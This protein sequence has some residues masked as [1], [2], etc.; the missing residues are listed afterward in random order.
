M[1]T[2][3]DL[4]RRIAPVLAFFAGLGSSAARAEAQ[5]GGDLAITGV[6]I[7]D[8]RRGL[9]LPGSAVILRGNRIIAIGPSAA[10][11]P[12]AGARVIDG[13]GGFLIPGL[14]D[15]HVHLGTAG[16]G[17]L[18]LFIASGVTGVRDMGSEQ[19]APLRRWGIEAL[20]GAR[21]GPRIVAAG[22]IVDGP[23]PNWPLRVTVRDSAEARR[24]VDSLA[25]VGVDFIKVHAQLGREAYFGIAAEARR[26]DLPFAGHVPEPVTGI[27]ASMAGQRSLE[28][29]TGVPSVEDSSFV[30][31]LAAF[32]GNRTWIDPTLSVYW[33]LAHLT[34]SAVIDDQRNRFVTPSLRAFWDY[35]KVGWSGD[36]SPEPLRKTYLEMLARV[37]ALQRGGIPLLT[38]TDLGF[39]YLHAGSGIHDELEHLVEAGL[40]PAEALRAS[41]L[42]PARYLGREDDFGTVDRGKLADLV[43]L[44]AN[45]LASIGNVRRIRV[46]IANGRVFDRRALDGLLADAEQSR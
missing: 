36:M 23:T 10:T 3:R 14:W 21:V 8:I 7:V 12:P 30:R 6:T 15:L 4:M 28:H 13:R 43:L 11:R 17:S 16:E 44:D 38:G 34:D 9:L 41:T 27:E 2:Q 29:M 22:P 37:H 24:T 45:P 31:T 18:P 35:Q 20:A 40:S 33:A 39:V 5:G 46:V 42:N 32:R 26:L 25:I 19:F 1:T